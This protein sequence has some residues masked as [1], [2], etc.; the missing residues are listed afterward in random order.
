LH[1]AID[2]L[3]VALYNRSKY[4]ALRNFGGENMVNANKIKA[5]IVELGLTQ[6]DLAKALGV[7]LPTINQKIN[8]VRSMDIKEAFIIADVLQIPDEDFREYF[9]KEEIA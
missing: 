8:N 6:K 2:N 3:E 5:R 4:I 1:Y 7:A 9:F